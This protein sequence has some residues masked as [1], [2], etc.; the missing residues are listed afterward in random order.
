MGKVPYFDGS[1]YTGAEH[2][3]TIG[4]PVDRGANALVVG[5]DFLLRALVVAKVPTLYV[6]VISAKGKFY[7]ISRRPLHIADT[8]VHARVVVSAATGGDISAHVSQ[9]PQ[10]DSCILTGREQQV[11][12]VRIECKLVDLAVVLVQAGEFNA[13]AVQVVEND[14]AVCCGSRNMRAEL[15]VRPLHV[16]DAQALALSGV[17]ICIVEHGSTQIGLV[18]NLG[19]LHADRLENLLASEDCMRALAVDVEGRDVEACLVACILG[20]ACA[21]AAEPEF[22]R[23]R[24]ASMGKSD[25]ANINNRVQRQSIMVRGAAN[26]R[27]GNRSY[28]CTGH[29]RTRGK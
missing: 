12:L 17:G 9:V 28:Y 16:M 24:W 14:L 22:S 11:A 5:C 29:A 18:D 4:V 2:V 1:I 26:Q 3:L 19:I 8:A 20:I 13:R 10:T 25:G 23:R 27:G 15:A 6:T 21:D 7:S